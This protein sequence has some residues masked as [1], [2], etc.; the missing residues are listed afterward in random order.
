M[1]PAP[2]EMKAVELYFRGVD[3]SAWVWLNG[4]YV[5]QHDLGPSGWDKPFH[6]DVTGEILWGKENVLA[7]RV[8]DTQYG[9]G[10]WRPVSVE[11][12]K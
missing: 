11:I 10:I 9:G 12:L 7:V 8:E 1:P 3:E 5:G 2:A 4:K 6:L